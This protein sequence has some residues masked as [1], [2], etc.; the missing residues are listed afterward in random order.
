MWYV[1]LLCA[2]IIGLEV[3]VIGSLLVFSYVIKRKNERQDSYWQNI[4]IKN[5]E[6]WQ[7]F[8]HAEVKRWKENTTIL[9]QQ[10]ADEATDRTN[11]AWRG[12]T[13]QKKK[14]E[15]NN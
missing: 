8:Y 1:N 12:K 15:D 5:H 7:D 2:F 6:E 13:K 9:I 3:G 11:D 4:A 10:A 14:P